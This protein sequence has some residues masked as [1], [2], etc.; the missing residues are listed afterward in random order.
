MGE[1]D[2]KER[3]LAFVRK[4]ANGGD[5][6]FNDEQLA[7]IGNAMNCV[8]CHRGSPA[9]AISYPFGIAAGTQT[10]LH[11]KL[12]TGHMP[13]G[14]D[15][16]TSEAYL[17]PE[18]RA[19]LERCLLDE[20]YGGFEFKQ[21]DGKVVKGSDRSLGTLYRSLTA[22]SC[23]PEDDAQPR[24]AKASSIAKPAAHQK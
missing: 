13:Q 3:N 23:T 9:S 18:Q 2:P 5:S 16:Q 8:E 10:L 15:D 4:C 7:K 21:V 1:V 19:A 14:A 24:G 6:K 12:K 17:T 11:G 20:Y 22:V